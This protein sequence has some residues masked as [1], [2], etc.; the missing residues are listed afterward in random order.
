M[1]LLWVLKYHCQILLDR[2]S[3]YLLFSATYPFRTH[4]IYGTKQLVRHAICVPPE[5]SDYLKTEI[6]KHPA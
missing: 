5:P 2:I 3:V 6:H 1:P 4:G